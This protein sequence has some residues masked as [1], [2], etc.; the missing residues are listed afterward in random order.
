MEQHVIITHGGTVRS[1]VRLL[2][3][4]R[5]CTEYRA[6]RSGA[7]SEWDR[8]FCWY[9]EEDDW[10]ITCFNWI[11]NDG[12]LRSLLHV[13]VSLVSNRLRRAGYRRREEWVGKSVVGWGEIDG[14]LYEEVVEWIIS[15]LGV[16]QVWDFLFWWWIL[17]KLVTFRFV[18]IYVLERTLWFRSLI[19]KPFKNLLWS[20]VETFKK[21]RGWQSY[22]FVSSKTWVVGIGRR[23]PQV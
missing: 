23:K 11:R 13:V 16:D 12:F 17:M 21:Q 15:Q 20:N 6:R 8:C 10:G 4:E 19:L 2:L 9:Q 1:P 18:G 22:D 5:D 7:Q 3:S 14:G